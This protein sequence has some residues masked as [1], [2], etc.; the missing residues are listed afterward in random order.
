[1]QALAQSDELIRRGSELRARSDR[2]CAAADEKMD[3]SRR[4]FAAAVRAEE[5]VLRA[6][7]W[8]PAGHRE[9]A[10]G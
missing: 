3:K 2:M 5:A 8:E 6:R 9:K 7:G 4:L 1:M 10:I